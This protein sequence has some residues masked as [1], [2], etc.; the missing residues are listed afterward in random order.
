MYVSEI[1]MPHTL[2]MLMSQAFC[3]S[4]PWFVCCFVLVD[5]VA[6]SDLMDV[7]REQELQQGEHV[8]DVVEVIH[9]LTALYEKLEEERS[10]LV[11]VPLC[12]DM[13][14]NFLLNVYDRWAE[15]FLLRQTIKIKLFQQFPYTQQ[16]HTGLS[17]SHI[18]SQRNI[19]PPER[20]FSLCFWWFY[21]IEV[22]Q[23]GAVLPQ[24]SHALSTHFIFFVCSVELRKDSCFKELELFKWHKNKENGESFWCNLV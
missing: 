10:I 23:G 16:R 24:P 22:M 9:G 8:M 11:N 1:M 12:V 15:H 7:F 19:T 4:C 20:L 6:L 3:I 21:W 13:C 5:L 14:L 17:D 2:F 18:T